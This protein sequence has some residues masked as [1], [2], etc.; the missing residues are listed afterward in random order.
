MSVLEHSG[1]GARMTVP[2]GW[3]VVEPGTGEV[4]EAVVTALEPPRQA[5]VGFRAN[6]VLSVVGTGLD[7]RQ[8]Q[9]NTDIM[10]PQALT[11]FVLLDLERL[12]VAGHPGG[13]RLA[14]HVG[15]D[16]TDLTLEQ[17]FTLV[18]G[19]GIT[20]SAT[21]DS[22]RYDAVADELATHARSLSLPGGGGA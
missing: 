6:L 16:G 21:V 1:T 2:E 9:V 15:P 5:P 4:A 18:D 14:R 22:W 10:L 17:W 13:R 7:F 3:E 19:A 20:V 12:E 11:D 8:W